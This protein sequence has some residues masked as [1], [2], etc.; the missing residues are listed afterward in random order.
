MHIN[1][2]DIE[3]S[4][5]DHIQEIFFILLWDG[6][7]GFMFIDEPMIACDYFQLSEG[8]THEYF[9]VIVGY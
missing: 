1:A 7:I 4:L 6:H 2:T 5:Y 9:H 8:R 3:C